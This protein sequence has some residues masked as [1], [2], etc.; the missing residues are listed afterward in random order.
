[1]KFQVIEDN[2][3][4]LH[5]FLLRGRRVIHATANYEFYAGALMADIDALV[6]GDENFEE[7]NVDDPQAAYDYLIG[8]EYGAEIIAEG[9]KGRLKLH[10]SR[11][12]RAAQSEFGISDEEIEAAQA[13]A[14]LGSIKSE[15]KARTSAE[16]GRKGGRP[17]KQ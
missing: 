2:G 14:S 7:S 9:G 11:M 1:M 3:G 17:R 10:K 8:S 12:G 15:R 5:L 16:N 13:A 6:A 4:G